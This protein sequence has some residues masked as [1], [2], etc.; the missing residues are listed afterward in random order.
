MDEA[1]GK[2]RAELI[3]WI[4]GDR[5]RVMFSGLGVVVE[6]NVPKSQLHA[7]DRYLLAAR[8]DRAYICELMDE[9]M[10]QLGYILTITDRPNE[11]TYDA[12]Q[13]R[14]KKHPETEL[15]TDTIRKL[16]VRLETFRMIRTVKMIR[17]KVADLG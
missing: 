15:P 6:R 9:R 2:E 11:Y 14:T 1:D 17:K 7:C 12:R 13:S 10:K 5:W 8:D 3:G 4:L 16:D